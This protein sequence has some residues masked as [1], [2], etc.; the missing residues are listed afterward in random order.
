QGL[1]TIDAGFNYFI[2]GHK[3]KLSLNYQNRPVVN[4]ATLKEYTRKSM[5]VLQFQVAI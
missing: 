4:S 2:D 1:N 5:M 3:A